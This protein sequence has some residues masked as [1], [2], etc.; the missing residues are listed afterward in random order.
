MY[1]N[2][3]NIDYEVEISGPGKRTEVFVQGCHQR[4]KGCFNPDALPF[5][6]GRSLPIDEVARA[7]IEHTPNKLLTICGG[8]PLAQVEAVTLLVR[9]LKEQGFHVLLYTG[10]TYEEIQHLIDGTDEWN[11]KIFGEPAPKTQTLDT[12]TKV[13]A[14]NFYLFTLLLDVD[15][16]VDGLFQE[17]KVLPIEPGKYFGSSNQRIIDMQATREAG[18]I[19]LVKEDN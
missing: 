14:T 8:E 5:E 6:G 11:E 1:I 9:K 19:T 4:C 13:M 10:L 15:I 2:I 3:N 16:L 12:W 7:I 17:D 18:E